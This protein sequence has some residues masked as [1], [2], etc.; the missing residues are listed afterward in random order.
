MKKRTVCL[1]LICLQMPILRT[2]VITDELD[3]GNM[4]SRYDHGLTI[5]VHY[6]S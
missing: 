2:L 4:V 3:V 1:W 6:S 5:A